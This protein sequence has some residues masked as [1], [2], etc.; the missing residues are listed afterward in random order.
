MGCDSGRW[1]KAVASR[2]H[3]LHCIDAS[4]S[5]LEVARKNLQQEQNVQFYQASFENISLEDSSQDFG[6]SLGV[7]HHVPDTQAAIKACWRKL[8]PD[9]HFLVYI[10]YAFDHRPGWFKALWRASDLMRH[11]IC[12]LPFPLRVTVTSLIA[13]CVYLP[14]ARF[15]GFMA[16]LGKN[17]DHFP[18]AQYRFHSFYTMRT[19]AL[20]RL[21]TH[22]E[23]RF[24]LDEIKSMMTKAGFVQLT[25]RSQAP[26]WCVCGLKDKNSPCTTSA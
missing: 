9:A 1:A 15:A 24:T 13:L 18:L 14:L 7:L 16:K 17:V 11:V 3:Q 26:F 19:D 22:L 5:A 25:H 8:K 23:K 12:R 21:G 2:V 20:D 6:Y 10:Y 4:S